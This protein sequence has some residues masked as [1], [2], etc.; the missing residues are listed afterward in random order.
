MGIF[1]SDF[2]LSFIAATLLVSGLGHTLRPANFGR[3]I[4][5]HGV[6]PRWLTAWAAIAVCFFELSV[7]A[8]A[9]LSLRPSASFAERATAL[10]AAAGAGI[11]FWVYLRHLLSH[12]GSAT[13]CGCSPLSA[14]LTAASLAPSIGLV[15]VSV[16]G[17][18]GTAAAGLS[19]H[20]SGLDKALPCLW[21]VTLAGLT[22]LYP[23]AV[24]QF[25][26][27]SDL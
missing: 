21:G 14:P 16:L 12:P 27:R 25:P 8:A 11:G 10:A 17:F 15:V 9:A 6:F 2:S 26:L 13:T 23:A 3:V 7:G 19:T 22:L 20:T 18:A 5:S 1:F 24:L 4:G